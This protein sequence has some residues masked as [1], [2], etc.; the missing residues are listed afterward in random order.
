MHF[1]SPVVTSLGRTAS[2]DLALTSAALLWVVGEAAFPPIKFY[3]PYGAVGICPLGLFC[4]TGCIANTLTF[5]ETL[6]ISLRSWGFHFR[7]FNVLHFPEEAPKFTVSF[8]SLFRRRF[9]VCF[10]WIL[11]HVRN[12]HLIE[13]S[14]TEGPLEAFWCLW[15]FRRSLRS[16]Q[17]IFLNHFRA[18]WLDLSHPTYSGV[19]TLV[20]GSYILGDIRSALVIGSST[21]RPLVCRRFFWALDSLN[22]RF[23]SGL[24][25]SRRDCFALV[26]GVPGSLIPD[27]YRSRVETKKVS[28]GFF[29]SLRR[30]FYCSC[31]S[32]CSVRRRG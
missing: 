20:T 32:S 4:F 16:D 28:S 30:D 12:E 11:S 3:P 7:F 9:D 10:R 29:H 26:S 19:S 2:F 14:V 13:E 22:S 21:V 23:F 1:Q 18:S 27:F 25:N 8:L 24:R 31:L 17:S 6:R 15:C 5:G